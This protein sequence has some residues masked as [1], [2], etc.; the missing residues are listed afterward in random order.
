MPKF[1]DLR[2]DSDTEDDFLQE[3]PPAPT[4]KKALSGDYLCVEES[5]S[6]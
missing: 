4:K 2:A 1:R 5:S 3:T 6:D